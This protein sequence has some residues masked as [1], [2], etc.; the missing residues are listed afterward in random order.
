MNAPARISRTAVVLHL[1]LLRPFMKL[2][3]GIN[4]TGRDNLEGMEQAIVIA[5]HNS[6]LDVLLLYYLL[7][8]RMICRTHP[9]AD[10]PHFA[11]S[12]VFYKLIS[13][14]L[15][16]IWITRGK[17][18]LDHDPFGEIKSAID[19]GRNVI[20]FPEGTRGQ[21][22]EMEHFRSGI[23]RLMAQYPHLPIVPVF[24]TG[25]DRVLP[26]SSA[27]LLPLWNNIIVGPPQ[28]CVGSHREITRRLESVLV[29]LSRSERARRHKRRSQTV[30]PARCLA[31]LGIDGSGKSTVSTLAAQRFS[32]SLRV[33]L[34]SDELR[35][36]ENGHRREL[37]PLP[38]E[39]LR[40]RISAYAKTVGSL[41]QYKI[42]KLA[43][44]LLRDRLMHEA[45]RWYSPDLI[46]MDGSPLLNLLAWSVLYQQEELDNATCSTALGILSGRTKDVS[47]SNSIF[48]RFPELARM[49]R[50]GLTHL[51]LPDIV[52]LIDV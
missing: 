34:V 52:I 31:F 32:E 35:V 41:K 24:L 12:R 43:E 3:C 38:S 45:G 5:N 29:D 25:P 36:F 20:I 21:P 10:Q 40:Q 27:L 9:V 23:G 17:P 15:K 30:R 26:K 14:L 44:L 13:F 39:K 42:P 16:P 50:L 48:A 11:R 22:G 7:P 28:K 49:K 46:V 19:S 6:H 1:I 33:C 37:Q 2:F 18:D 8:V 51:T 4:V 47:R